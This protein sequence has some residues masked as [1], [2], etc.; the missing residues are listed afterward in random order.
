MSIPTIIVKCVLCQHKQT[1]PLTSEM[2]MCPRCMG[3]V[4]VVGAKARK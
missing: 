1:V 3:P 4:V 2:P